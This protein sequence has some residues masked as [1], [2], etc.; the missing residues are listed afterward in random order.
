M[1]L[2]YAVL[3]K[4]LGRALTKGRIKGIYFQKL[5]STILST[6]VRVV[7]KRSNF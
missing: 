5:F 2:G 1:Y 4:T 6:F 7:L 3:L